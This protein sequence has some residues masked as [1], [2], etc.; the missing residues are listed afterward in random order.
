MPLD[1]LFGVKQK[2]ADGNFV[3]VSSSAQRT[4]DDR[5]KDDGVFESVE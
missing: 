1:P 5:E 2:A 4:L 3:S